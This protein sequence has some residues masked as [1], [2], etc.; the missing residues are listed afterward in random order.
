M[1]ILT[2]SGSLIFQMYLRGKIV[3]PFIISAYIDL[4][5]KVPKVL[6][7]QIKIFGSSIKLTNIKHC[8]KSN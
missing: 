6:S 8:S 3:C 7:F 5:E 4:I 2:F 1:N